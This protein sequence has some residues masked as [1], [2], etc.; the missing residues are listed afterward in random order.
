MK[1]MFVC[2]G[3]ICRSPMAEFIMKHLI[4]SYGVSDVAV[5][6]SATSTEEIWGGIGSPTYPPALRELERRG[7]PTYSRRAVQLRRDDYDKYD[8]IV[9]MDDKNIRGIYR[10]IGNDHD[11]KVH[12]LLDYVGSGRDVSDPWY[13]DRFDVAFDDIFAG[14]KALLEEIKSDKCK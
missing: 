13:S 3:N 11:K 12:K 4:A 8:L 6:S 14:C 10:I 1:I 5:S 7:I 2:H 9:G